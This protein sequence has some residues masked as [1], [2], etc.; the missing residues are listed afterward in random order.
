MRGWEQRSHTL[1]RAIPYY[2]RPGGAGWPPL[3]VPS[4]LET[5][6]RAG[7][8]GG[9]WRRAAVTSESVASVWGSSEGRAVRRAEGVSLDGHG[10]ACA[11]HG[12]AAAGMVS[13]E[14]PGKGATVSR[15]VTWG[16]RSFQPGL[17]QAEGLTSAHEGKGKC[18]EPLKMHSRR[19]EAGHEAGR[20]AGSRG[21][22]LLG[23][24]LLLRDT[25][26]QVTG[27]GGGQHPSLC[28]VWPGCAPHTAPPTLPCTCQCIE[29]VPEQQAPNTPGR[30]LEWEEVTQTDPCAPAV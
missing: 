9:P 7:L 6:P 11:P 12:T 10:R 18:R 16:S 26:G 17:C 30:P 1:G 13:E 5:Q 3:S 28:R 29:N 24:S 19:R 22:G 14:L 25:H 8:R 27:M 23:G 15:A 4:P 2:R 20:A 21:C